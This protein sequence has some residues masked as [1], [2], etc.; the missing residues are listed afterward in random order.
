MLFII[1]LL[2]LIVPVTNLFHEMG[3]ALCAKLFKLSEIHIGIGTGKLLYRFK[4]VGI[5]INIHMLYFIGA[6]T[7]N[8]GSTNEIPQWQK[9]L[10]S[11]GGPFINIVISIIVLLV[12]TQESMFFELFILFN[13]WVGLMNL[14]PYR[15]KKRESDGLI[16]LKSMLH[17]LKAIKTK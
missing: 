14:L 12:T 11:L 3:H 16:F 6:Y 13:L 7:T 4:I 9:G 10:I 5:V 15:I 17:E 8:E 1:Y 2:L